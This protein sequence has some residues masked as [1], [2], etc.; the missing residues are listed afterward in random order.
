MIPV[1]ARYNKAL[2]FFVT[3]FVLAMTYI[4]LDSFIV[5]NRTE[6]TYGIYDFGKVRTDAELKVSGTGKQMV[7]E[8]LVSTKVKVLEVIT[9]NNGLDLHPGDEIVVHEYFKVMNNRAL[10]GIPIL[11]GRSITSMGT[12]YRRLLR[13][14]IGIVRIHYDKEHERLWIVPSFE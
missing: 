14:E 2:F 5:L 13:G 8:D 4:C 1:Q 7:D 10:Y 6:I 3:L 11:P 9:V 12:N